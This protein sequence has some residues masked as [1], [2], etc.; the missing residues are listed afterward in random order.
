MAFGSEGEAFIDVHANTDPYERELERKI[1]AS[2]KDA[3][4]LLDEVGESWGEHLA[5]ST[6]KEL[7]KHGDDLTRS[8]ERSVKGRVVHIDGVRYVLDRRGRLHDAAGLFV[9]RFGEEVE[10]EVVKAA[11]P[12][13][14][15]NRIGQAFADAIGAGFSVSGKSPLIAF[16][17]PL[18][19]AIV[20]LVV[21]AIQALNSLIALAATLPALLASIG[22]QVGVLFIA[23]Q[24]LGTAIG[25]AF[26]AKNAKELNEAVKGL[27]PSARKFVVALLPLKQLFTDIKTLVQESF[28][29]ALGTGAIS[30]LI[31]NLR[32]I[33]T[34]GLNDVALALGFFF[35]QLAE[36]F[37]SPIFIQFVKDIF[38]ATI[39]WIQIAGPALIHLLRVFIALADLAL[40]FLEKFGMMFANALISLS[41][42]I[43]NRLNSG[44]ARSWLDSM[45]KTL[46]SVFEL[47][48]KVTEFV[49]VLLAQ[50]NEA[51]G[52]KV[53]D[54]LSEF[55]S[56]LTFFL[57][58]PQGEK[59]MEALVDL[60]IISIRVIGGLLLTIL[61][62]LT[63]IEVVSEAIRAFFMFLINQVGPAIGDWFVALFEKI[64]SLVEGIIRFFRGLYNPVHAALISV[65]DTVSARLGEV[66]ALVRGLPDR[67][68]QALSN[69]GRTLFQAGRSLVQGFIDGIKSMVQ[70]LLDAGGW[71]VGQISRFM[72]GSPAE[73]GPLSGSGYTLYRGQR[74]VQDFIRG[75]K[76]EAPELREVSTDAMSQINFGRGAIQVNG[77]FDTEQQATRT[78]TAVGNGINAIL[79][80][81]QTRL[82]VR[83][84]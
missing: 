23:F 45:E 83:T 42:F 55:F 79:A 37:N 24:G 22:V 64:G 74:M 14:P 84:L 60:A 40:P 27:E 73:E 58:T 78:G 51:G 4:K 44:Q 1:K 63:T 49:V 12:G 25:G 10:K 47:L 56:L 41:N 65:R 11:G 16:L 80:A 71:I 48:A 33:L 15:L 75:I 52:L 67:A 7:G 29:R 46:A 36:F 2:S 3:E 31:K 18:V 6:S 13:G 50:L 28:F 59:A 66:L 72:P 43:A 32:P 9:R 26:A 39:R 8:L 82:A 35:K 54:E 61:F 70:P 30:D 81:Q 19:G 62:L 17:V 57:S 21:A 20:G 34:H 68:Q 38:P 53:I 77:N 76:M 5:D 69:L